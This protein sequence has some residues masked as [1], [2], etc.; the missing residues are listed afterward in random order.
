MSRGWR[1]GGRWYQAVQELPVPEGSQGCTWWIVRRDGDG[2]RN[3][4][5]LW[6]PLP[7]PKGLDAIKAGFLERFG[8]GEPAD[9]PVCHLGFD[10]KV[11]WF[12]QGLDGVPFLR[13][14]GDED[15]A[16]RESLVCA[17]REAMGRSRFPRLLS[18]EVIGVKPGRIQVPRVLG[19]APWGHDGLAALPDEPPQG[20]GNARLWE[21]APELM[22]APGCPMRGRSQERTYT[23]SLMFGLGSSVPMERVLLL[24]GEDGLGHDRLCDWTAAAAESEGMWVVSIELLPGEKAG[25]FLGRLLQEAIAGLEADLYAAEPALAKALARRMATFAFLRGGRRPGFA[26]RKLDVEEVEAAV[27]ALDYAHARH[28]RLVQVRGLERVTPEILDLLRSLAGHT[29]VPWL[30]SF[31]GMGTCQGLKSYLESMRN[32]EA[33]ATVVLDRLEDARLLEV[34]GDLLGPR[35]LPPAF[36]AE[37]CQASLGNP[38]LLQGILE[39]AILEGLL[40]WEGGRWTCPGGEAPALDTQESRKQAILAGRLDRLEPAALAAARLLALAG[41]PLAH[42]T[43]VRALGLDADAAE[44]PLQSLVGARLALLAEGRHRLPD[45]QVRDLILGRTAPDALPALAGALVKAMEE[46]GRN[47][48]FAV[49]LQ[50]CAQGRDRALAQVVAAV[51]RELP[52]PL[53]AQEVVAEALDLGPDPRQRARLW[54]FLADAWSRGRVAWEVAGDRSPYDLAW[55]ALDQASRALGEPGPGAEEEE[56]VA[57]LH[58]KKAFLEIRQRRFRDAHQSIRMAAACLAD[59]PFHAEQPR[60]RLAL[61]RLHMAQGAGTKALRALEEGLSLLAQKGA[62]AGHRDEVALLLEQGR[63]QGHRAQFQRALA[64]LGAAKRFLE[65][66][67]DRRR[68]AGVAEALGQ[69]HLGLGQLEAAGQFFEEGLGFARALDDAGL[70]AQCHLDLGMLRSAQQVLGPAQAHLDSALRRYQAMGDRPMASRALTWK[71]R[72]LAAM[73]DFV[74]AEFLLVEASEGSSLAATPLD[75][76]EGVFLG[77]ELAAF[78]ESWREAR[79]MYLE[80]ANRFGEAGFLWREGLARLR[81]IQ[82]ETLDAGQGAPESA[83]VHLER[84]KGP[85]E[86]SGSR[87]LELEWHRA[88]ALLLSRSGTSEAVVSEALLAWGD[89]VALARE[90][91]FPAQVLEA[92]TRSSELLLAQGEKLGA[93]SRIQD[94]LPALQ[95]LWTRLPSH[96][97]ASFLARPDIHGF[98]R[99]VE[100]AG[101]RFVLPAK[102]DPLAD[103]SPTQANL[104]PVPSP[105]VNP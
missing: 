86:G 74:Q 7:G 21:Q 55:E 69:A 76:A 97:E 96:F 33:A 34:L 19:T 66:E 17:V 78:K 43:L 1:L 29:R 88:H 83:W 14:W 6:E 73:G 94:A 20:R 60:L 37:A 92:E 8:Q 104:P 32:Q 77:G 15:L 102:S 70:K 84:L 50:A 30:L 11:A 103:W 67:G 38:G 36:E 89:V 4:L 101:I 75:V 28:P 42:A 68:L 80:A 31:R 61:G 5:Q 9:P 47:P 2:P 52:G 13:L 53:E 82:A 44:A 25:E 63:V 91:K 85:V 16:G 81:C 46:E 87:W 23:K 3:L 95:E 59:H 10:D 41:A 64:S 105:R 62:G 99:A 79:R 72:T 26:D 51:E 24:L 90:L 48:A 54:E 12:L 45:G 57:R 49:R 18:P 56:Q 35:D 98:R 100:A 27:G 22:E 58:R 65:H 93:R 39:M 40:V 71:A